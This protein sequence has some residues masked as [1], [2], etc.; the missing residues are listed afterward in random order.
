[1]LQT[2]SL[3]GYVLSGVGC[4]SQQGDKY[5]CSNKQTIISLIILGINRVAKLIKGNTITNLL[6]ENQKY[7]YRGRQKNE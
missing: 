7:Y 5:N 3:T 6:V 4:F 1:L 2:R